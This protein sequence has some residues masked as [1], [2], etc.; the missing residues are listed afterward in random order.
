M[1][2]IRKTCGAEGQ[3]TPNCNIQRDTSW[4]EEDSTSDLGGK[5]K[6]KLSSIYVN[7]EVWDD[8]VCIDYRIC[9]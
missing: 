7:D 1:V 9:Q 8:G 6:S 3:T 5:S 2:A 4:S